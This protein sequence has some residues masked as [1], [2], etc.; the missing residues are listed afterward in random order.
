M[1]C[2]CG[3]GLGSVS[4]YAQVAPTPRFRQFWQGSTSLHL[5]LPVWHAVQARRRRSVAR[6]RALAL[7]LLPFPL[8]LPPLEGDGG[9]RSGEWDCLSAIR[10]FDGGKTKARRGLE[11]RVG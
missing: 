4:G 5:V 9:W 2:C 11:E 8:G 6:F 1:L 7:L 3:L 10:M